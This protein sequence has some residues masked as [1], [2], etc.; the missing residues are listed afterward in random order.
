MPVCLEAC[1]FI[2]FSSIYQIRCFRRLV[3]PQIDRRETPSHKHMA[4]ERK[5][6]QNTH[7][8]L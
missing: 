3:R 7:I 5:T 4:Q 1:V 2:M 6:K 8:R